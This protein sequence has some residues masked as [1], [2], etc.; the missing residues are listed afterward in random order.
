MA[1]PETQT[2]ETPTNNAP[3]TEP[4]TTDEPVE[5][6][7]SETPVSETPDP[8]VEAPVATPEASPV[9]DAAPV[10][11]VTPEVAPA[12]V[13]PAAQVTVEA[14]SPS[15]QL[16]PGQVREYHFRVVNTGEAAATVRVSVA[17]VLPG[18]SG[19]VV[20]IDGALPESTVTIEPGQNLRVVVAVV[21][22]QDSQQGDRN[23]T[24]LV[25]TPLQA[26]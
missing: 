26:A 23:T 3:T 5:T 22:P 9:P 14:I 17:N 21:A 18:W 15:D 13:V 4:V 19:Q 1:E 8:V 11:S 10:A 6:P 12:A 25:V 24:E 7:V 2:T 20:H 16:L